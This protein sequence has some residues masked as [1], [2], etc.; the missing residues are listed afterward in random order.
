MNNYTKPTVEKED[1][2]INN[3]NVLIETTSAEVITYVVETEILN[4]VQ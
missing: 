3:D 2:T 4:I 1:H